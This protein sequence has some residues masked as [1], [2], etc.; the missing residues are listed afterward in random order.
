MPGIAGSSIFPSL[1]FIA[2]D[3]SGNLEEVESVEANESRIIVNGVT[4][5]A[6]TAGV[7]GDSITIEIT[8]SSAAGQ[9]E[10]TVTGTDILVAFDGLAADSSTLDVKNLI[11]GD[12]NASAL[13]SVNGTSGSTA[14]ETIAKTS[15]QDGVDFSAGELDASSNYLLIKQSDLHDLADSEQLDGRKLVW[16]FIN[17]ATDAFEA[18]SAQPEN[19]T[20]RKSVPASTDSGA[21]LKQTFTVTAKYAISGLDLKDES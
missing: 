15:L 3:A 6:K 11:D 20:M 19:L 4:F 12:T 14:A 13:I 7:A 10:V 5:K 8:E 21:A 17:K 2:T 1:K 9:D 18:M 16:G